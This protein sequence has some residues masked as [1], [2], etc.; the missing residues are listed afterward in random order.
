MFTQNELEEALA[1]ID[2]PGWGVIMRHVQS[3]INGY[4]GRLIDSDDVEDEKLKG[5][6]QS[7]QRDILPLRE[8]FRRML[9]E[10]V[11]EN[12]KKKKAIDAQ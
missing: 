3:D 7:L 8:E 4:I 10:K 9:E 11:I 1:T 2:T 6:I 12:N 5:N